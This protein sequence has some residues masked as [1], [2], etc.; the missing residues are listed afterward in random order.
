[1]FPTRMTAEVIND[2]SKE[3]EEHS[4]E[5]L[6]SISCSLS[7]YIPLQLTEDDR[8]RRRTVIQP[9]NCL[10][11]VLDVSSSES[12]DDTRFAC[13]LSPC[14]TKHARTYQ[15]RNR[16]NRRKSQVTSDSSRVTPLLQPIKYMQESHSNRD[17]PYASQLREGQWI[18]M[19][20]RDGRNVPVYVKEEGSIGKGAFGSV[21][22]VL[23][24]V[25]KHPIE[26]LAMKTTIT[27]RHNLAFMEANAMLQL[28]HPNC[29][30]LKYYYEESGNLRLFME[31]VDE[32]DLLHLIHRVWDPVV[33]L[34][35]YCELFGFQIFRGL[36]YM[37]SIGLA[38]RDIKPDNVLISRITGM[39]KLTDFNCSIRMAEKPEHSPRVGTKTYNAPELFLQSRKYNEKIDIWAAG[40]V[41]TAMIVKKSIFY[42]GQIHKKGSPKRDPFHCMLEYLGSPTENDFDQMQIT[43]ENRAECPTVE[44]FRSFNKALGD[45]PGISSK[46]KLMQLLPGLFTYKVSKRYTA[47]EV[48]SHSLFDY[49]RSGQANLENGNPFPDVFKFSDSQMLHN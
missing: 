31:M 42:V 28:D 25:H 41:L 10:T 37:H 47:Y 30:L 6:S 17:Y 29:V 39:A 8:T 16:S 2:L 38:H 36:A 15:N 32:G 43:P 45:A 21:K 22:S 5:S 40:V 48:C 35:V 34:G 4:Q 44:K 11:T 49:I 23:V 9:K 20:G 46:I 7:S 24:K 27:E 3:S 14:L 13:P 26:R 19:K 1:M 33:G 12:D 18:V